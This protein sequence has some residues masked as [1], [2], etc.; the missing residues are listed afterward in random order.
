[1]DIVLQSLSL[2]LYLHIITYIT[3]T[4]DPCHFNN[5][6]QYSAEIRVSWKKLELQYFFS[7][8]LIYNMLLNI[9]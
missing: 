8:Y 1:M 5:D 7:L 2:S 4:I 6:Y 9:S 3:S